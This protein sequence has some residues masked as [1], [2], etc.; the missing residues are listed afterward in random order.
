[1]VKLPQDCNQGKG[2]NFEELKASQRCKNQQLEHYLKEA[3]LNDVEDGRLSE[4]D[5]LVLTANLGKETLRIALEKWTH[6]L[7]QQ[8]QKP[9]WKDPLYTKDYPLKPLPFGML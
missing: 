5:G 1:M 2:S 4:A 3:I 6:M 7:F 8:A 9:F